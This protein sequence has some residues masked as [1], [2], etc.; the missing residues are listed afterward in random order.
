MFLSLN[1]G[2]VNVTEKD[3]EKKLLLAKKHGFQY[4]EAGAPEIMEYGVEKVK[5]LLEKYEMGISCANLPFHP[6][7]VDDAGFEEAIKAL[8][9]Q[10][11][12]LEA[13]GCT[14]CIIWIFSASDTLE[15]EENYA[16]HV[17]RLSAAAAILKEHGIRLGLEFIGPYPARKDRKHFMHT[18][19]DMMALAKDCGDNVGL[20]FDAYHWYTGA[21]NR[22]VFEH[23]AD[24][25]MI[26][27]VHVNDAAEGDR[28]EQPDSP[29]KLPGETDVIDIAFVMDGLRKL[30]YTGPV[31]AEPFSTILPTL[32]DDDARV[33]CVKACLD[34][35]MAE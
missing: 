28:L 15:K 20:L 5:A 21:N 24:A 14:R 6:I 34:K 16:L 3:F 23:I 29:R 32:E 30:G 12:A 7:Q 10:A 17:K 1:P 13:V 4:I 11:T 22:D 8:P 31:V 19:E 27:N 2:V 33:A 25:N 35:I 18:A 9:A 26:V